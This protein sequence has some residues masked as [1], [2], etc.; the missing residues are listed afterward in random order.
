MFI[1]NRNRIL[2]YFLIVFFGFFFLLAVAQAATTIGDNVST[3]GSITTNG[4]ATSTISGG[5]VVGDNLNIASSTGDNDYASL[6]VDVSNNWIGIAT[7]S[8]SAKL[9][10]EG[11]GNFLMT[12]GDPVHAGVF[13][14]TAA[15]EID[16]AVSVQVIQNY[17][18]VFSFGVDDGMTVFDVT[19]PENPQPV[20]SLQDSIR[21]DN[22]YGTAFAGDYIYYAHNGRDRFEIIDVSNKSAP[23]MA[24]ELFDSSARELD[25]AMDVYVSGKFAYVPAYSDN[26]VEIV[27]ISNPERPKHAG[28]I[29]D[30]GSVLLEGAESICVRGKYM[31][32]SSCEYDTFNIIDITNRETPVLLGSISDDAT[33]ELLCPS[34]IYV[35]GKYAY[36]SGLSDDGLEILDISDPTNPTHVGAISDTSQTALDYVSTVVVS[37]KYAYVAS[38]NDSGVEVVDISDR[39][40]PKHAGVI[41]GSI[42]TNGIGLLGM[43]GYPSV[44]VVGKH[45]YAVSYA[46]AALEIL[47]IPGIDAPSA[48]IGDVQVS[49]MDTTGNAFIGNDL[50][51][52][53]G[54]ITGSGGILTDGDTSFRDLNV[55]ATSTLSN[56][57]IEVSSS[58]ASVDPVIKYELSTI[59]A[60]TTSGLLQFTNEGLN[61]G[62]DQ[63]TLIGANPTTFLGDFI[64]LQVAGDTK[65][66]VTADGNASTTGELEIQG[67]IYATTSSST[68]LYVGSD[69][70][71]PDFQIATAD[72]TTSTATIGNTNKRSCFTIYGDA[73][74]LIYGRYDE[75]GSAM[76]W[77]AV[78]CQ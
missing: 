61:G 2:R 3:D 69:D 50:Y 32:I 66:K 6:Y 23:V 12:M 21:L 62:D 13:D 27:N 53:S 76:T 39:T 35:S 34:G 24:G 1:N 49:S 15:T 41:T 26:G 67:T 45:A 48:S 59:N 64:H 36:V 78:S 54:I 30:G 25:Y 57:R 42:A 52:N 16:R 5:L 44:N 74:T 75:D 4:T 7:S 14:D 17:A 20:G 72:T 43:Y 70:L 33:T 47:D 29:I 71:S 8:P 11:G 18:I 68:A 51:I 56:N 55:L 73:G 28:R 38:Y 10:I 19:N 40:N 58:T 65:F 77:S 9:A 37:G 22:T 60:S 31:Y 46:D 63:G